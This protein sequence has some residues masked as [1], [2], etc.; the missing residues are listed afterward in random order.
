M[1]AASLA[2]APTF[3]LS[4]PVGAHRAALVLASPQRQHA[5][6]SAFHD[7]RALNASKYETHAKRADIEARRAARATARRE[8]RPAWSCDHGV[9]RCRICAGARASETV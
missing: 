1:L 8:A 5:L 6:S 3:P 9:V 2:R 4:S 7:I